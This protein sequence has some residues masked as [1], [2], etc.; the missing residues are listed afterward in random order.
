ML[1]GI[2]SDE[3][4]IFNASAAFAM[5]FAVCAYRA[6]FPYGPGGYSWFGMEI[7]P[8]GVTCDVEQARQSREAISNRIIEA[9]V[10]MRT[11]EA[12]M[13]IGG[14]SQ[15]AIM[16]ANILLAYP[17]RFA[18]G[19]FMSGAY[20]PE[21][22]QG[23]KM[24]HEPVLIQHGTKDPVIPLPMGR[25]FKD[26]MKALGFQVD[27]KEYVMGHSV[28][29]VSLSDAQSWLRKTKPNAGVLAQ[30]SK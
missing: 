2:G 28:I 4:D 16:A 15:G 5:T 8:N 20:V 24:D 1:H 22:H 19:L 17:G 11:P 25:K 7:G 27:H 10:G 21:L 29:P 23:E 13:I 6:P 18:G 26:E 12:N 14:F 30:S 9:S 3:N